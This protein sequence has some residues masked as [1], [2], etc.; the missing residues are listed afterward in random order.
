MSNNDS[1]KNGSFLGGLLLGSIIVGGVGAG[2]IY[3]CSKENEDLVN[4]CNS[5]RDDYNG[6][7]REWN[8]KVA[9]KKGYNPPSISSKQ[10]SPNPHWKNY[11]P[12]HLT[13]PKQ[14]NLMIEV[15][16]PN[17]SNSNAKHFL[18]VADGMEWTVIGGNS[19]EA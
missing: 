7:V 18:N 13:K 10:E 3:S 17:D 2:L 12:G 5:L 19:K 11:K 14:E 4:E 16:K 8:E 15:S 9:T 6:L 1:K